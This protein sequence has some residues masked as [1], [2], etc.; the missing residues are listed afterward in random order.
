MLR[1][2]IVAY[3]ACHPD[4]DLTA[5]YAAERW[6]VPQQCATKALAQMRSDGLLRP[7]GDARRGVTLVYEA[8]PQLRN[9]HAGR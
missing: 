9:L 5:R 8:T 6:G 4:E 7:A 3:F 2:R 1:D